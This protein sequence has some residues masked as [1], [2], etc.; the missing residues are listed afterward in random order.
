MLRWL[1]NNLNSAFLIIIVTGGAVALA[2]M[3]ERIQSHRMR[4]KEPENHEMLGMTVE[5]VGIA[6]AIL[7]G[8]VIVSLWDTQ[9]AANDIVPN[10]AA[11]LSDIGTLTRGM[12]PPDGAKVRAEIID[13]SE[14]IIDDEFELLREGDFSEKAETDAE[15][16]FDS[17]IGADTSTPLYASMQDKAID[18]YK[19]FSDLRTKRLQIANDKLAGELWL[20]VLV[21]SLALILLVAAFQGTGRWDLWASLIIAGT[22]GL[23]LF[24]MVAL[25]Y[26]FSG[27]VAVTPDAF[28]EVV[29]SLR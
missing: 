3:L 22:V 11:A 8:F 28:V 7:I 23:V 20:L 18:S 27:D 24:A 6:Y 2:W 12:A 9:G 19:E 16:L 21:S 29:R 25:S 15:S 10:E 1:L 17:I 4:G 13:Y 5:F 26:P 14:T